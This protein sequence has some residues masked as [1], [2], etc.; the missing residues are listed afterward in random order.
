MLCLSGN[1]YS[2]R[3]RERIDRRGV[4]EGYEEREGKRRGEEEIRHE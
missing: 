2:E 1:I 3:E 4:R